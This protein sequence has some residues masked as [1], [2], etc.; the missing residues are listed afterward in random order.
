MKQPIPDQ[1]SFT[2][3]MVTAFSECVAG[4]C[5]RLALSPPLTHEMYER[6]AEEACEIIEKHG[7][8][9][10]HEENL[11]RPEEGRF[12]WILI[13]GKPETLERYAALRARGLSPVVSLEPFAE[14]LSYDP[15]ES[16]HTGYDA[17]REFFPV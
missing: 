1:R 10:F 11:D 9:H 15:A 4:G 3:G 8:L 6:V 16:V 7:L 12:E 17:Y 2:L 5:K 13:A 14:L